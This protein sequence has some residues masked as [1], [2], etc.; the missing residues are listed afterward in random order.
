MEKKKEAM[1][2]SIHIHTID[3]PEEAPKQLL[4]ELKSIFER[5]PGKERIQLKIGSQEV[6]LPLTVTMSTI[7]EKKIEEVMGRYAI[8]SQ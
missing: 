5:F 6:P 4:L 1:P 8:I 3:L 2:V 7:L